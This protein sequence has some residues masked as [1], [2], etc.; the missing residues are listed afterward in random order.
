MPLNRF[1]APMLAGFFANLLAAMPAAAQA[2]A[3]AI[4]TTLPVGTYAAYALS[5]DASSFDPE[6][7]ENKKL[8]EKGFGFPVRVARVLDGYALVLSPATK[9]LLAVPLGWQ[10]FDDGKRTRLFPP[11]GDIGLV[12]SI[13]SL[14]GVQ[15]WDNV[16]E[17]FWQQVRQA[18]AERK[19]QAP[20]Y[21]ARLI[22]LADGTFG[23]RETSIPEAGGPYSSVLLFLR[24]PGEPNLGLRVNLFTPD[25]QFE[26]YLG[27]AGLVLREI[28]NPQR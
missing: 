14:D 11:G 23:V 9:R 21:E 6:R 12:V 24:Y 19:R 27:L 15:G 8:L 10:G 2:P 1:H 5:K 20:R 28:Q 13:V 25:E 3:I 26:R 7:E 4:D 18:A 22:Q 17:H 16:R